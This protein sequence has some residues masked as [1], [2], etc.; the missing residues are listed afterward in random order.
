[1]YKIQWLYFY[2]ENGNDCQVRRQGLDSIPIL[3]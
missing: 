2:V 1:M 3:S